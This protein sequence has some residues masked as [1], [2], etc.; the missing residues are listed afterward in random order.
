MPSTEPIHLNEE[1]IKF[2][3]LNSNASLK[4]TTKKEELERMRKQR[5]VE[6][7]TRTLKL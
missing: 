7:M 2:Q 1:K 4:D 3:A 5:V 6:E